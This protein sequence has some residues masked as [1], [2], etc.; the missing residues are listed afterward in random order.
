MNSQGG[1]SS[2]PKV[3][4]PLIIGGILFYLASQSIYYGN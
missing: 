1:S 3:R 2:N 4:L